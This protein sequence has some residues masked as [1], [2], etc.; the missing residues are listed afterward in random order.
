MTTD[1]GQWGR[2][3][4]LHVGSALGLTVPDKKGARVYW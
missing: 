1:T 4:E 2:K 3:L